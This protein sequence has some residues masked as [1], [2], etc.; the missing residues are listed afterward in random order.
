MAFLCPIGHGKRAKEV[1]QSINA[2][3]FAFIIQTKCER[4]ISDRP[5][6]H[7]NDLLTPCNPRPPALHG[8]PGTGV[9]TMVVFAPRKVISPARPYGTALARI[10]SPSDSINAVN[11]RRIVSGLSSPKNQTGIP[12][13]VNSSTAWE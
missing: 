7:T 5:Y 13:R 10:N 2:Y 4:A 6:R 8:H 3:R 9:P 12:L 11:S 1:S